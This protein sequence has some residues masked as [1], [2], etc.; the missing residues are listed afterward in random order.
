MFI[1]QKYRHTWK[2]KA[3]SLEVRE[4]LNIARIANA[5]TI[6][7]VTSVINILCGGREE[8]VSL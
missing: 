4:G 8:G 1:V 6:I 2:G 5:V 7:E 3:G